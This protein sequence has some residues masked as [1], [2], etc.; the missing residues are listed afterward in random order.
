VNRALDWLAQA[1][2]TLDVT[3]HLRQ[4]GDHAWACFTAQQAAEF[5][6]KA[7]LES[8]LVAAWGH[9]LDELLAKSSQPAES[10]ALAVACSRLNKHYIPPRYPDAFPSG[11]PG[12]KYTGAESEQAFNDAQQVVDHVRAALRSPA[13]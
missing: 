3:R 1:E 5:A 9:D 7:L 13:A 8:R 6:L 12:R 4:A 2:L 11:V 10:C